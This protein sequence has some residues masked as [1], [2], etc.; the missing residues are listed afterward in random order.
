MEARIKLATTKAKWLLTVA[1]VLLGVILWMVMSQGTYSQEV[2]SYCADP[3]K[4][5]WPTTNPVWSLCWSPPDSSSGIDGSGLE[6]YKVFYKGKQVFRRAHLPVMNVIYDPGGCG[7]R[8]R[9]YRDWQNQ[10]RA[11]EANNI[12]QPGYAEPT[13]PPKTVCDHPGTDAGRFSGV[14]VEKK[15]DQLILTTQ[16]RAGWYRY[17]QKWIFLQDG[18][19]LPRIGFSAVNNRC[20][21]NPHTHNAYWR[22][23]FDINGRAVDAID[24]F[25]NVSWT[26]ISTE[27][28][29]YKA[30]TRK[31]RVID[32][33]TKRG[34]ELI[35]GSGDGTADAFAVAD[36]WALHYN[37]NEI[38]DGGAFTGSDQ[39]QINKYINDQSLNR[40]DVVLWYRAGHRHDN[41]IN[42]TFVGPTLKP[43][44]S[45]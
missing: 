17:T 4:I 19:I 8:D 44:G 16:M 30:K 36:V 41:G 14:A 6:L 10:L 20:I 31:W 29:R 24:E 34:Y 38:D 27:A 21:T 45:W 32:R 12:L 25:N 23:D 13:R 18:T 37:R 5:N 1:V 15:A 26:N 42:C 43:L 3:Y 35:P 11:F 39:A 2:P 9:S 7:G 33:V 22:F 40:Q 28:N